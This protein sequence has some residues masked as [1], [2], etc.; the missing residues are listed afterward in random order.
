MLTPIRTAPSFLRAKYLE[1][2]LSHCCYCRLGFIRASERCA[3]IYGP[4]P[5]LGP[6]A[7]RVR[8]FPTVA[9]HLSLES[10]SPSLFPPPPTHR[11][12]FEVSNPLHRN[13]NLRYYTVN[14]AH[15]PN[16]KSYCD[17]NFT[18]AELEGCNMAFGVVDANISIVCTWLASG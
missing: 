14:L 13:G 9:Y 11:E 10:D 8:F 16:V 17:S 7:A 1:L 15:V 2:E 12:R 18:M 3:F 6:Q 4:R 5:L